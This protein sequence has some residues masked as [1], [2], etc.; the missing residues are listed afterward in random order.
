MALLIASVALAQQ[1][2]KHE[3]KEPHA[4]KE[5]RGKKGDP[6]MQLESLTDEQR[7]ALEKMRKQNRETSKPQR[8]KVRAVKDALRT[9]ETA[10]KPNM[11]DINK[12][13]DE[14]HTLEAQMEKDRA[15]QR[16]QMRSVLTKEQKAELDATMEKRKT[17]RKE[18]KT[19]R[20]EMRPQHE[21]H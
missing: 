14:K 11:D 3:H 13:I 9:K 12:M 4:K 6:I 7:A 1:E 20:K 10:D 16:V 8:E 17:E 18:M 19:H 21:A 15:A 2:A 5:F